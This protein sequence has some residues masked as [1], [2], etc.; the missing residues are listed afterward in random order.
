MI[1]LFLEN[2]FFFS[3]L[4]ILDLDDFLRG[5]LDDD[6]IHHADDLSRFLNMLCEMLSSLRTIKLGSI[7]HALEW[8]RIF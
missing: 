3:F 1:L 7:S 4:A 2:C 6:F 8:R 5:G